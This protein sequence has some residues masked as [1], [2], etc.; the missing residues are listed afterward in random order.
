MTRK[1]YGVIAVTF[2]LAMSVICAP[3]QMQESKEKPRMYS[4]VAFWTIPR[5]QWAEQAKQTATEGK[6]MEK[7]LADGS[8]VGYGSDQNLIHQP[9]GAT[10]DTWFSS[11]SMAGLLNQLDQFYKTGMTTTAVDL[12]AT[13]HWDGMYVSR[14]YNWHSGSWKDVYSHVSLYQLK[15]DAPNDA[16]ETLSK[17]LFVP[18]LEKSL[19]DGTIH[20][21]EIDTEAIHTQA[22]GAI[23]VSYIAANAEALDKVS[24]A[25][26]EAQKASPLG[27]PAFESMADFAQ[28][29]DYLSKTNATY[30]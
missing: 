13:K 15:A 27:G 9:D 6:M 16:V 12:S 26:R 10:H 22:P 4:Y 25:V 30:K 20:E 7:A 18:I 19:A 28:H 3:A 24:A 14:F 5:A 2:A 23:W 11:M 17:N 21:Y 1:I 8:I 29:R